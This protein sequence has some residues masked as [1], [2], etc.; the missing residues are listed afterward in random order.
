[1]PTTSMSYGALI[2]VG[3][4]YTFVP[5]TVYSLVCVT[6]M[7]IHSYSRARLLTRNAPRCTV[8]ARSTAPEFF[9]SWL[10]V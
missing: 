4:M 3:D 9:L 2:M 1:M 10:V 8:H 6:V 7:V 5:E